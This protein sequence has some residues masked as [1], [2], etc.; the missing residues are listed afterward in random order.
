MKRGLFLVSL[1]L[2]VASCSGD[3]DTGQRYRAERDLWQANWEYRHLSIRPQEVGEDSWAALARRYEAIASQ[4]TSAP[5][6]AGGSDIQQEVQ[7]VAARALFTAAQVHAILRDSIRV[8]QIYQQ[9]ARDF[10]Q[11][12]EV[13]AEV[14]LARGKISENRKEFSQAADLYQTI[15]ERVDPQPDETGVAGMVMD[16]PL[17]IARLRAQTTPSQSPAPHFV[18]ARSHYER[19]VRDHP[20][21]V[22]QIESQVRL[23]EVA[24]DLGEW[25]KAIQALRLLEAQLLELDE[26]PREPAAVRFAISGIQNRAGAD[27]ESLRTTLTSLLEDYPDS[28]LVP[29]VLMLLAGSANERGQLD[30]ALGYLDRIAEE[31]KEN[32]DA[33][34]QALLTRGRLLESHERW[35]EALETYRTLPIQYPIKEAALL[36]PLEIVKHYSRVGD[37]DAA[38]TAL[39][40]AEREYRDFISRYP[41]GPASFFARER[42]VQTLVLQTEYESALTEMLGLADDL[43]R[44]RRGAA[45][46]IAAAS[47]AYDNLADTTRAAAILDHAGQVYAQADIGKWALDEAARLRGTISR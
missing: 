39:S 13:A 30:E 43:G 20:S 26:P 21:G 10:G 33:A 41:P 5:D 37:E 23:A 36:A 3:R 7:T 47:M 31:H 16:L 24:A 46:L 4:Y 25:G 19:L 28:D 38:A 35:A 27:P 12:T 11:L 15:V 1:T 34:S 42:L 9:M 6:S 2:L 18:A 32:T 40:Q 45:L 14:A 8:E 44:T 22:I 29:Q 17:R